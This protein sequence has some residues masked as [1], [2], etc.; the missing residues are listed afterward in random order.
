MSALRVINCDR[1]TFRWNNS[2]IVQIQVVSFADVGYDNPHEMDITL[3]SSS[4]AIHFVERGAQEHIDLIELL[5]S[6]HGVLE[7]E[8]EELEDLTELL[9]LSV[10]TKYWGKT[11]KLIQNTLIKCMTIFILY[12]EL[13]SFN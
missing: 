7:E 13:S 6:I 9:V 12:F 8:D 2:L 1:V 4:G 11:L 10:Y 5:L 3:I